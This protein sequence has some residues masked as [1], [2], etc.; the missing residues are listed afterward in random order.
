MAP[1]SISSLS[2]PHQSFARPP[3][4][5]LYIASYVDTPGLC[6]IG[7]GVFSSAGAL[8]DGLSRRPLA[9]LGLLALALGQPNHLFTYLLVPPVCWCQC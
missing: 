6:R 2:E 3:T 1:R 7:M 5:F 9:F 4:P 8:D